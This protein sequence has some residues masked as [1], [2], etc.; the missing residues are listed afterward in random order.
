MDSRKFV[1]R[2]RKD[3]ILKPYL[4]VLVVANSEERLYNVEIELEKNY[5]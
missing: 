5:Y 2:F 1:F 3:S 4:L